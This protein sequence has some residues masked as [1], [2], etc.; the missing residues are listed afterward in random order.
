MATNGFSLT[1]AYSNLSNANSSIAGLVSSNLLMTFSNSTQM[2]CN[3]AYSSSIVSHNA[4]LAVLGLCNNGQSASNN[5]FIISIS[6]LLSSNVLTTQ[7]NTTQILCNQAYS[8][9]ITSHTTSLAAQLASNTSFATTIG[10]HQTTL[11]TLSTSVVT[12]AASTGTLNATGLATL[13][14]G[15]TLTGTTS[16]PA[17]VFSIL[18]PTDKGQNGCVPL[19][20]GMF[21]QWGNIAGN[22]TNTFFT[23][24]LAFSAIPLSLV[25]SQVNDSYGGSTV[26]QM[27]LSVNG[28]TSSGFN[29]LMRGTSGNAAATWYASW[30]AIG[31]Y[32]Y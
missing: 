13:S 3:Q 27:I 32:N 31:L 8:S 20:N 29:V 18:G 25:L 15:T 21:L 24:R 28:V 4:S 14:G 23:Y 5:A 11:N 30:M 2:L 6:G 19:A 9:S 12:S 10:S 16:V 17:S 26:G 1:R 7:S 22:T